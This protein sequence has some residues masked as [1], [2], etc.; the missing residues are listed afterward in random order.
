MTV[1]IEVELVTYLGRAFSKQF[2]EPNQLC[3]QK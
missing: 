1:R 3:P 2:H